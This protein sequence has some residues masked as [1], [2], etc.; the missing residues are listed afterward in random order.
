[1]K[2]S[3]V[4]F[5]S[6]AAL[7]VSAGAEGLRELSFMT[8]TPTDRPPAIDGALDDACWAKAAVHDSYFEYWIQTPRRAAL[9]SESREV[10]IEWADEEAH[11]AASAWNAGSLSSGIEKDRSCTGR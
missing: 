9:R 10:E 3:A 1:M 6:A 2:R 5:L 4:L 11:V 8:A 7:A